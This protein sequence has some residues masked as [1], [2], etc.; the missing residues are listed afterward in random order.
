MLNTFF[1]DKNIVASF[2]LLGGGVAGHVL[3]EVARDSLFLESF[4]SSALPWAYICVAA[5]SAI[6][7]V[8]LARRKGVFNARVSISG[9]FF[10]TGAT[11]LAFIGLLQLDIPRH[12]VAFGLYVWVGV[13][14]ILLVSS[15]WLLIS[16]LFSIGQAKKAYGIISAGAAAGAIVG[17]SA[18]SIIT[19]NYD[20][21]EGILLSAAIVFFIAGLTPTLFTLTPIASAKVSTSHSSDTSFFSELKKSDYVQSIAAL[22]LFSTIAVT[23]VDWLFKVVVEAEIASQDLSAF[24][25]RFYLIANIASVLIQVIFLQWFFR[26]FG[27]TGTLYVFPII[28]LLGVLLVFSPLAFAAILGLKFA[29]SALKNSLHKP[30]V[31]LLYVPLHDHVRKKLKLAL[32]L[33]SL[34]GGQAFGSI[35]IL[36]GTLWFSSKYVAL[37]VILFGLGASI[38]VLFRL[39][40]K[41]VALFREYIREGRIGIDVERPELD[42]ISV[43]MLIDALNSNNDDVVLSAL[44]FLKDEGKSALISPLIL[45]HPS[46]KIVLTALEIFAKSPRL[47]LKNIALRL[48]KDQ[49]ESVR[50]A[51]FRLLVQLDP[52]L[53]FL[54]AIS[55]SDDI[56]LKTSAM[57]TLAM[58][59][60]LDLSEIESL[61]VYLK[62]KNDVTGLVNLCQSLAFWDESSLLPIYQSIYSST[63]SLRLKKTVL[64]T[65]SSV[66][67]VA[68]LDI[69]EEAY[70][71]PELTSHAEGLLLRSGSQGFD[72][73]QSMLH[74]TECAYRARISIPS[75]M[76]KFDF[77]DISERLIDQFSDDLDGAISFKILR[78]LGRT[79]IS[80]S[81][82]K[83]KNRQ[84]L[85]LDKLI[86]SELERLIRYTSTLKVMSD[87]V[88][89]INSGI[90]DMLF[91]LVSDRTQESLERLFRVLNLRYEDDQFEQIF[92]DLQSNGERERANAEELLLHA[93]PRSQGMP[94]IDAINMLQ[95]LLD[96][97][98]SKFNKVGLSDAF[99]KLDVGEEN[100]RLESMMRENIATFKALLKDESATISSV[101]AYLAGCANLRELTDD[102]RQQLSRPRS[103]TLECFYAAMTMLGADKQSIEQEVM[104]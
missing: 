52:P 60:E 40:P 30:A 2:L 70:S 76:S 73:L 33:I 3:L 39:K 54:L 29:D 11:V 98:Q 44:A 97:S 49:R 86:N 95:S 7:V 37:A 94:A 77:P 51:A 80:A 61:V 85:Q 81:S 4:S 65:M 66:D 5:L 13:Y 6:L 42:V 46:E 89:E 8:Y 56:P 63:D 99:F 91:Q 87:Q 28:L 21:V 18:A 35:L 1:K 15:V 68:C 102:I 12:W 43:E 69:A 36:I 90:L 34:R 31:E 74:S 79:G 22:V 62:E 82:E 101:T 27:A 47:R 88:V 55:D 83:N 10:L 48:L 67:C 38:Y 25:A 104:L 20:S 53:P 100:T 64:K 92:L 24:F 57:V 58:R 23:G 9:G 41:Y 19:L 26:L 75:S 14:I 45:F 72:R 78:A 50:V 16:S 103:D 17:S 96:E 59:G 93:I 32:D 84:L 71:Q